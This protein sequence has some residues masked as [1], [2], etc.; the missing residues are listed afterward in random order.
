MIRVSWLIKKEGGVDI[1]VLLS[2]TY[3]RIKDIL[4]CT[5]SEEL[6][7]HLQEKIRVKLP[8]YVIRVKDHDSLTPSHV[9]YIVHKDENERMERYLDGTSGAMW[10]LVN[11]LRYNPVI[12]IYPKVAEKE[13]GKKN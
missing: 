1:P 11:E 12:G 8:I 7:P 13:F 5:Y 9:V 3:V 2:A 6:H 10:D 4:V